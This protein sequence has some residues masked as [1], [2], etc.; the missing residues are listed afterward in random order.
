MEGGAC[1][2]VSGRSGEYVYKAPQARACKCPHVGEAAGRRRRRG[3]GGR[4]IGGRLAL[5]GWNR[6]PAR[7]FEGPCGGGGGVVDWALR[8]APLLAVAVR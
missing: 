1:G 3:G 8:R 5:L 7:P 6:G 4:S 2:G